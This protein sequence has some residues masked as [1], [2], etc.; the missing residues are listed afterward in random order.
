MSDADIAQRLLAGLESGALAP[1]DAG[2]LASRIDPVLVWAVVGYLRASYPASDR[3]ASAVLER[4]VALTHSDP[5]VVA[6][7][8]AGEA[9]PVARWFL[10]EY[11]FGAWRGRGAEMIALVAEKLDT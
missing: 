9:D 7:V 2:F 3:A 4:V 10:D 1:A 11:G 8:R 5:A 6:A